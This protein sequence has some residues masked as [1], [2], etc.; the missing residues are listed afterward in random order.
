MER[1]SYRQWGQLMVGS[2]LA[3]VALGIAWAM[4][5]GWVTKSSVGLAWVA[6]LGAIAYAVFVRPCVVIDGSGVTLRNIVRDVHLPWSSITGARSSWNLVVESAPARYSS[7][8][9]SGTASPSRNALL[10]RS[11]SATNAAHPA[12]PNRG[13]STGHVQAVDA[14][15]VQAGL[16][17]PA[18]GASAA[19]LAAV[20]ERERARLAGDRLGHSA[21]QVRVAWL[22]AMLLLL[23]SA[24]VSLA[25]VL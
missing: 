9:I 8:A 21:V 25:P 15:A 2:T 13:P 6:L 23:A 5:G 16:T 1:R 20:V 18:T 24:A 12:G 19:A 10:R 22:P 14:R 3:L 7:W 4:L 17:P 11:L